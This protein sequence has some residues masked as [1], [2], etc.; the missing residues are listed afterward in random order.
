MRLL[1]VDASQLNRYLAERV[2]KR[3]GAKV[4]LT[5]GGQQAVD[6]LRANPQGFGLVSMDIQMPVMDGISA[7][8]EIRSESQFAEFPIL[9]LTAG[10][11]PNE[12]EAAL[13]AGMNDF[14]AKPLKLEQNK[15]RPVSLRPTLIIVVTA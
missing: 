6:C 14:L 1:V 2:L 3:E 5:N 10:V 7:T 9:A 13:N 8:R 4:T 12:R 15:R 11:F